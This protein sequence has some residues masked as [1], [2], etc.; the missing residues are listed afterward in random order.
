MKKKKRF[1][2]CNFFVEKR[3]LLRDTTFGHCRFHLV[4]NFNS[5]EHVSCVIT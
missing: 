4:W 5:Q 1:D 3:K 2:W